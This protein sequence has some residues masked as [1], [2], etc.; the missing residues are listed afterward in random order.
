M[1]LSSSLPLSLAAAGL[2]TVVA[3]GDARADRV[4][5]SFTNPF[6]NTL[7]PGS[8][9]P[10]PLL[11]AGRFGT[12]TQLEQTASQ[13]NLDGVAGGQRFARLRE[14]TATAFVNASVAAHQLSV[15]ASSG[16]SG[17]LTLEYGAINPMNLNL[18][19]DGG[20]AFELDINGDMNDGATARPITL[21]ITARTGSAAA[22]SRSYTLLADGVYQL[23]FSAFTG[24]TFSDVDYLKFHFDASA[25]DAV[26][27]TLLGGLRTTGCLQTGT[28]H[29]DLFL[30]T[31]RAPLPSRT[32]PG[33]GSFAG[34]WAGTWNGV[35]KPI[36]VAAQTG[37]A[38][39][40]GGQR[41]TTLQ[42]SALANFLTVSTG[43]TGATP[44][45]SFAAATG[46]SGSL[47]LEY[48]AQSDLNANLSAMRAFELELS[49][50]LASGGSPRPVPLTITVASSTGSA[51]TSVTLLTNGT[52]YVPFTAF[53]GVN[54]ANVD[55]VEYH[56]DSTAVSSVDYTLVGGLRASA[57]LR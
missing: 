37:L 29:A 6:P 16:R 4:I 11:W 31:F 17:T 8:S 23:P 10:S 39:T 32:I 15:A 43:M 5:D 18:V 49:G 50:D 13:S 51:A 55:W 53:P 38:G 7:L 47:V 52:Y 22:V 54:F 12:A 48:G 25:Y 33:S 46:L 9:T 35:V 28:R 27:Y 3:A 1:R 30:D 14:A 45:L 24:V 2:F 40:I 21:T 19:A 26:D 56:F 36:D 34:L 44:D 20:L 41:N 57:C 42:A